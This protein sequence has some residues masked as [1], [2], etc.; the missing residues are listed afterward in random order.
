MTEIV[1]IG[2]TGTVG[3]EVVKAL[4]ARNAEVRAAV[5]DPARA[6]LAIPM[7]RA[8]LD[9]ADSLERAFAGARRLFLLTAHSEQVVAQV[10]RAVAAAKKASL[11]LIVR[12]SAA[13]ASKKASLATSRDHAEAEERIAGSGIPWAALR[14]NFFMIDPRR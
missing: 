12:L 9:D 8:D 2:A 11:E 14:P 4:V 5:R 6:S 10:E 3:R 1:L 13:G 7:V